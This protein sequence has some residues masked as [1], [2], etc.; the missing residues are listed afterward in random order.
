MERCEQKM[1]DHKIELYKDDSYK[2]VKY[3]DLVDGDKGLFYEKYAEQVY[4]ILSIKGKGVLLKGGIGVG[5]TQFIKHIQYLNNNFLCPKSYYNNEV[6]ILNNFNLMYGLNTI[7]EFEDRLSST[8]N[9]FREDQI[10]VIDNVSHFIDT[11]QF[12]NVLNLHI[13]KL[14]E[15]GRKVIY[16]CN[17]EE[18]KKLSDNYILTKYLIDVNIKEATIDESRSIL[19]KKANELSYIYNIKIDDV[20]IDKIL[21]LCDKY[22]KNKHCYPLKVINIL[23]YAITRHKNTIKQDKLK[24]AV[25]RIENLNKGLSE[26]P[27]NIK[28]GRELI[29]MLDAYDSVNNLKGYVNSILHVNDIDDNKLDEEDVYNVISDL[30][31]INI[32]KLTDSD[33]I[34]LQ[35]MTITISQQVIGQYEIIDKVCKTIKRNRLGFRKKNHTIGNFMFL[36][37]TGVGKTFLTKKIAEY[38]FGSEDSLIRLDMSE[39]SDEISVN[40]LIGAPP[41]YVGY[42]N[43]GT[44]C[45]A[46]Q[47]NPHT[48]ILF[49]EIEKAHPTIYNTILQLMDE[50]RITDSSGNQISATNSIII[51]TSN[52]GVRDSMNYKSLGFFKNDQIEKENVTIQKKS[53]IEKSIR[54]KFSPEFLNRIDSICYFNDLS[55][56]NIY[57]IYNNEIKEYIKS[58]NNMGYELKIGKGVK[59]Y[60]VEKS[61]NEKLGARSLIRNIQQLIIDELTEMIITETDKSKNIINVKYIKKTNSLSI[62]LKSK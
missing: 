19:I 52:I 40:K 41:G 27:K 31:N 39:Y 7:K 36:G 61:F 56:D 33:V 60:I 46:I 11:I 45:S 20:I 44:L 57:S 17:N 2:K 10:I 18:Y 15:C 6:C 62:T 50:G 9:N 38:M 25:K 42:G 28:S 14:I 26:F 29:K 32:T 35:N 3:F 43:S 55:L 4:N 23:E 58:I 16:I 1:N 47:K 24:K 21:M 22:I 5:K 34:K 37:S 54:S 12:S 30:A 48:I 59:E 53:I 13:Q 51:M 49:D 8:F